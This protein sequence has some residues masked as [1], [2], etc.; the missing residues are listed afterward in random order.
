MITAV[1]RSLK[2]AA[3]TSASLGALALGGTATAA[4]GPV[5]PQYG[6]ITPFYGTGSITPFYGKITP[7]YGKITPFFGGSSSFW[8]SANPFAPATTTTTIYGTTTDAFWGTG[9]ADP[10]VT[11]PSKY[12]SYKTIAPFWVT[13]STSWQTLM[14]SWAAAKTT[15]DYTA[16]ATAL[17]STIVSP[18]NTFWGTAIKGTNAST[19][20]AAITQSLLTSAGATYTSGTLNAASLASVTPTNQA[21]F[22]LNFYDQMM[23]YSGTAHAD[24]W[25]NAADWS[26]ALAQQVAAGT[27]TL[28]PTP[29]VVGMLDFTATSA[30]ASTKGSILSYG[31]DVFSD[32]HG[33][34]VQGLISGAVDKSGILGVMPTGSAKIA[35]YNPYDSTNTTDWTSIGNGIATLVRPFMT[36]SGQPLMGASVIN[37]SLGVPGS[38]FDSG[39]STVFSGNAILAT[40]AA[41]KTLLVV[42]AGNEGISQTT[43]VSWDFANN[44]SLILVGSLGTDGTISNFS[45][46]PGTA[47]L[48]ATTAAA[49]TCT[50]SLASHFV[51]APGELVLIS[52]NAGHISRQTGTSLAAPLVTGAVGLLVARW[53]WLAS[54]PDV[55]SNIILSSAKPMGTRLTTGVADPVYGMGA[56]DIAASQSPLKWSTLR[57]FQVNNGATASVPTSLATVISTVTSASASGW[58]ASNLYFTAYE[59]FG[60]T[61]RDFQV[62][63]STKL[64]GQ[65]VATLNGQQT[66]QSFLNSIMTAWVAG[67][68]KL[69]D[70]GSTASGMSGFMASSLP[71]GRVGDM[72]VRMRMA[73]AEKPLGYVKTDDRPDSEMAFIGRSSTLR[74]GFGTMGAQAIGGQ[75]GFASA[76]DYRIDRGGANPLLGLASG[77]AFMDYRTRVASGVNLNFGLTQR[78]DLRDTQT[79]GIAN[80]VAGAG[81]VRYASSASHVGLD[82][83]VTPALMLH[84]SLTRL[85]ERAGLLGVQSLDRADLAHGSV[86]TGQSLGFDLQL[87][88]DL[89]ISATGMLAHTQTPSGQAL[90][91]GAGGIQSSAGEVAL[92][93]ANLFAEGD[94]ARLTLSRSLQADSGQIAYSTVGVI[95]RQ[96][97]ARGLVTTSVSAATDR[98]PVAFEMMYGRLLQRRTAD[99][100]LFLRLESGSGGSPSGN[101]GDV[102]AGGR[103][104]VAF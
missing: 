2:R 40:G 71:L 8:T 66:F 75:D 28:K 23:A 57:F 22:F 32:G 9:T 98:Q 47:C 30:G 43:N 91:T 7:F 6:K 69:V 37:A 38:T 79:F 27:A 25:M 21:M 104:H 39:W 5:L 34:A 1:T 96:T 46:K 80:R 92:S 87:G 14:T 26:P 77:G 51:V 50:Q 44:P 41:N 82:V 35:V 62:P 13:E 97:G 10:Y 65:S 101:H 24:W 67:G 60:S 49:G 70:S 100:S 31:S 93:K 58:S 76:D 48:T 59:Y 3:L 55:T 68:A 86:T 84:T 73:P 72:Q 90:H 83:S 61:Y 56:L 19:S 85:D 36:T 81:A 103:Y 20:V 17:Q 63:M 88:D 78:D 74:F 52:D 42:A 33:A 16:L 53:P 18:A 12:I 11:N 102:V 54:Q 95:D 4:T 99:A 45:N 15:A 64:V 89:V 29:L 94:R